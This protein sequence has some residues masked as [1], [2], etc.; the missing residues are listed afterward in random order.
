MVGHETRWGAGAARSRRDAATGLHRL[1]TAEMGNEISWL[2]PVALLAIVFGGYAAAR[3]RIGRDEWAAVVSWGGWL[4][5]TGLVFSYMRG[6]THPYYTVALAPA[7]GAHDRLGLGLGVAAQV[8][9][10]R[11]DAQWPCAGVRRMVVVGSAAPQPLRS[12]MAAGSPAGHGSGRGGVRSRRGRR[13]SRASGWCSARLSRRR[14]WS[15]SRVATAATPALTAPSHRSRPRAIGDATAGEARRHRAGWATRRPTEISRR[16]WRRDHTHGR[17]RP[18]AR[19]RRR[20]SS[21][22][23]TRR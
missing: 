23:R 14:A 18:T 4:V 9:V 20:P 7:V 19:N 5:V 13:S 3:G 21:S 16:C 15:R 22:R 6:T 12:A 1:F 2:L 11:S 8:G 10:G 17:R